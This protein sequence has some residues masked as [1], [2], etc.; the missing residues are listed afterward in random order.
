LSS[1]GCR[2]LSTSRACCESYRTRLIY[3]RVPLPICYLLS[4]VRAILFLLLLF[5]PLRCYRC[6]GYRLSNSLRQHHY[7]NGS[8]AIVVPCFISQRGLGW[9]SDS[10]SFHL[11]SP[12]IPISPFLRRS[13]LAVW[14]PKKTP[15]RGRVTGHPDGA[16]IRGNTSWTKETSHHRDSKLWVGREAAP[17]TKKSPPTLQGYRTLRKHTV[18]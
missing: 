15:N 5:F 4:F 18:E 10:P 9:T 17:L 2:H 1:P 13:R 3:I 12:R 11:T 8:F 16:R 14:P 6:I 7:P